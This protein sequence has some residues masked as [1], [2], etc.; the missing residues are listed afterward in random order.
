[1]TTSGVELDEQKGEF[2]HLQ[3]LKAL[4]LY[5]CRSGR[6]KTATFYNM[7]D[8]RVGEVKSWLEKPFKTPFQVSDDVRS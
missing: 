5:S 4:K 6:Q 8:F 2:G 3:V 7:A 1:M